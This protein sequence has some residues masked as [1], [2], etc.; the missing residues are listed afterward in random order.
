MPIAD[1]ATQH[2]VADSGDRGDLRHR[3]YG[4]RPERIALWF[5]ERM[6]AADRQHAHSRVHSAGRDDTEHVPAAPHRT[7]HITC[8]TVSGGENS[9]LAT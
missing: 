2:D 8:P 6:A 5:S 3:A 4:P 7:Q 1:P 9:H